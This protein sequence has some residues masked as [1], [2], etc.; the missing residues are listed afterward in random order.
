MTTTAPVGMNR[1]LQSCLLQQT[2]V[3]HTRGD[4][5]EEE[6]SIAAL[7]DGGFVVTWISLGQDGDLWGIL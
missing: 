3:P 4:E 2:G 7:T 6:P 1:R 5:P